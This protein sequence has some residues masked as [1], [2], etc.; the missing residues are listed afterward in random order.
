MAASE[1]PK[2]GK[3]SILTIL[4]HQRRSKITAFDVDPLA[5]DLQEVDSLL[6]SEHFAIV[7]CLVQELR[8]IFIFAFVYADRADK[9]QRRWRDDG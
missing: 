9:R 1:Q 5:N 8:S 3:L 2:D 7:L 4:L 6:L